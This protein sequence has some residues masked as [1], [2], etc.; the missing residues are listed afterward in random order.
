MNIL[1]LSSQG[2][3]W[4]MICSTG[5]YY[6]HFKCSEI[7]CN[8]KQHFHINK[9]NFI[10]RIIIQMVDEWFTDMDHND[11]WQFPNVYMQNNCYLLFITSNFSSLWDGGF[12]LWHQSNWSHKWKWTA[13][14]DLKYMHLTIQYAIFLPLA[15]ILTDAQ[16]DWYP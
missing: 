12:V 13:Y 2:K 8:N 4:H 5:N 6:Y 15:E 9:T 1:V 3:K 7:Y 14:F 10:S 11:I 16:Y